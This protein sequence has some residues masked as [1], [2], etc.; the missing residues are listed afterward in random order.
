MT[1]SR[2]HRFPFTQAHVRLLRDVDPRFANW[3]VVYAL[4]GAGEVYV[5]E[6][7]SVATRLKQHLE[8]PDRQHLAE[9]RVVLDETFNKSA[10]LDLESYLI[11]LFAGD[12]KFRVLNRNEGVTDAD[13]FDRDAYRAAFAEIAEELR[14]A[15]LFERSVPEIENSDLFKLSPFKALNADQAIA[16]E[17]LLDGLFADIGTGTQSTSVVQGDPGTG[18]TVV[19]I[20]LIKLLRDI[21]RWE[22]T[23]DPVSDSVFA[24]YFTPENARLLRDFRM[25]LVVPQQ[26]L[27]R[28]IE[29]VFARTPGLSPSMVLTPFQVGESQDRF[30]LLI[31]DETHRLN[32]RANQATGVLNAK[33]PEINRRL[34]GEDDLQLTQLDWLVAQSDHRLFLVD[35]AQR[36]RPADLPRERLERLVTEA[37]FDHRFHLRS[38]MRLAG[39]SDYIEYVRALLRPGSTPF[40]AP[41]TF[42]DYEFALYDDIAAMRERLATA[43]RA[44]GLARLVAGYAWPWRSRHDR[45]AYDISVGG[46][47][48]RW[49]SAARDWISSP[50]SVD[51]VG[52]VHTVQGYDLNVA[53]VIIGPDL[54][55]DPVHKR[56]VFDRSNYFDTKGKENNPTLGKTYT[57]DELLE[58]VTNIYAVLLTRGM[59]GTLVYVCDAP[60][61]EHLGRYI[62][63]A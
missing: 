58:F 17:S 6:S 21:A 44:H 45:A 23:E 51:E 33:F 41:Q 24:E 63:R 37:S 31:V 3:P 4:D 25:A 47:Q 10:C 14:E 48:L 16:L 26:S 12:G 38:Q 34:F 36:V 46:L 42:G 40:V 29:K 20:Y 56:L 27:R 9:A 5:G 1:S 15:G 39:G 30:D 53:G 49:N 8:N 19:A 55:F 60:L 54:R 50:G 62:P 11:R 7:L 2:V 35:A 18:K 22:P 57:D 52:S 43:E 13:Y 28:T 32:Q 59:R 61:R